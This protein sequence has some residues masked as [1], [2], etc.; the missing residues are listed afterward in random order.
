MEDT[1][2]L[3]EKKARILSLLPWLSEVSITWEVGAGWRVWLTVQTGCNQGREETVFYSWLGGA[4]GA[5]RLSLPY[6]PYS[7]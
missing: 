6:F 3:G 1:T 7:S 5:Y 4:L 2:T